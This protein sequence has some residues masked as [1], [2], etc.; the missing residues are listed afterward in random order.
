MS[1]YSLKDVGPR[2]PGATGTTMQEW[3]EY[4]KKN[5]KVTAGVSSLDDVSEM[6]S[7]LMSEIRRTGDVER[8]A[9]DILSS[10]AGLTKI[11]G[12]VREAQI[13]CLKLLSPYYAMQALTNIA[14]FELEPRKVQTF[15]LKGLTAESIRSIRKQAI[16]Q[17]RG[18]NMGPDEGVIRKAYSRIIDSCNQA[19]IWKNLTAGRKTTQT[20]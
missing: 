4:A 3:I 1:K 9:W 16:V 8:Q 2:Y 6:E 19:L 5:F 15:L 12:R 7:H 20:R 17:R 11:K 13:E 14:P 10:A 18:Y